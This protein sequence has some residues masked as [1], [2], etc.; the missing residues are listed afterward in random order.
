MVFS[1]YI[2][3]LL[4]DNLYALIAKCIF[5]YSTAKEKI[6]DFVRV[7]T[8]GL[9]KDEVIKAQ[10]NRFSQSIDETSEKYL[11]I[12]M[13]G[14]ALLN[15]GK[16]PRDLMWFFTP[17]TLTRVH[18]DSFNLKARRLYATIKTGAD[19]IEYL[20]HIGFTTTDL[21]NRVGRDIIKDIARAP[22]MGIAFNVISKPS[23]QKQSLLLKHHEPNI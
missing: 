7:R 22:N 18:F 2:S 3:A 15:R 11:L 12:T 14:S 17:H 8:L 13:V 9:S 16:W 1:E 5:I 23:E 20:E 19:F 4:I 10:L 6:I 21:Y